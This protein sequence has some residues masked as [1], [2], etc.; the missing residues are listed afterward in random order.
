[1][2]VRQRLPIEMP[3]AAKAVRTGMEAAIVGIAALAAGCGAS[4]APPSP[5]GAAPPAAAGAPCALT[6]VEELAEHPVTEMAL[7]C[8]LPA[9]RVHGDGGYLVAVL[10][11]GPA[12]LTPIGYL[13]RG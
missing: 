1:M 13:E 12:P 3:E 7:R 4:P 5:L 6:T 9:A 11:D 10:P 8:L 2:D